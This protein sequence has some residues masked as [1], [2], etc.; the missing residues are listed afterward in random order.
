[1]VT[2]LAY[3]ISD[4]ILL[5]VV[6]GALARSGWWLDRAWM[7]LAAGVTTFWLADSL[8]LVQTTQASTSR[9]AGTTR[10]GGRA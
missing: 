2:G 7:L 1:V 8:F 5:G 3:P 6:V 4:L 10:A 9:A